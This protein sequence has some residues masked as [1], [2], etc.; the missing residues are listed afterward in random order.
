MLLYKSKKTV[1]FPIQCVFL[2]QFPK[3]K[4]NCKL[5]LFGFDELTQAFLFPVLWCEKGFI[6]I[7]VIVRTFLC[8]TKQI[9]IKFFFFL[10]SNPTNLNSLNKKNIKQKGFNQNFILYF[11]GSWNVIFYDDTYVFAKNIN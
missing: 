5:F 4:M 8:W 3:Y 7:D 11:I 2:G 1:W 10:L 9:W 6:Q